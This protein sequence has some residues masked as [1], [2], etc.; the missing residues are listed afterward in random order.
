MIDSLLNLFLAAAI[1]TAVLFLPVM[2]LYDTYAE[3]PNAQRAW[4]ARCV[5]K[6]G[7]PLPTDRHQ[8]KGQNRYSGW[9]WVEL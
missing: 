6:G 7:T 9:I 1:G 3:A 8:V 5:E 2:Y 4:T